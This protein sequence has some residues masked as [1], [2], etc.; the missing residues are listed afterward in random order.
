MGSILSRFF[1]DTKKSSESGAG[2]YFCPGLF[3]LTLK[4]CELE[5]TRGTGGEVWF[6]AHWE[7]LEFRGGRHKTFSKNEK[8]E[9]VFQWT[10]SSDTYRPGDTVSNVMNINSKNF[11]GA[12]KS[13]WVALL[14]GHEDAD[15]MTIEQIAEAMEQEHID[16]IIEENACEGMEMITEVINSGK[17]KV[18][19]HP[20][21]DMSKHTHWIPI[22]R[23]NGQEWW[24]PGAAEDNEQI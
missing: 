9:G 22:S 24:A 21:S 4:N 13:I 3:K 18:D 10:D 12:I 7:I 17:V 2:N 11:Q 1:G 23:Y 16:A 14:W 20:T 8:G 6:R 19:G 5:E 15:G